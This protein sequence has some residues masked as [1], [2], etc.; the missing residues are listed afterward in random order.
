MSASVLY[1]IGILKIKSLAGFV[2][3]FDSKLDPLIE[4]VKPWTLEKLKN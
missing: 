1:T 2:R 4:E 3:N